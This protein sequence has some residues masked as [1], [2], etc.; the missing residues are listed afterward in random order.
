MTKEVYRPFLPNLYVWMR[1]IV[2]T[3]NETFDYRLWAAA[4][5]ILN[6]FANYEI[7]DMQEELA[8]GTVFVRRQFKIGF[9]VLRP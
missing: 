2:A 1:R 5:V 4:E 3:A 9:F 6:G 7:E 8:L